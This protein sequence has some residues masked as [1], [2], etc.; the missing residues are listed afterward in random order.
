MA[1]VESTVNVTQPDHPCAEGIGDLVTND[2]LYIKL[3]WKPGNDVFLTAD[4]DGEARPHGDPWSA[5]CRP[6]P[7]PRGTA[8]P[9]G[10]YAT[11]P[12]QAGVGPLVLDTFYSI[13]EL[14]GETADTMLATMERFASTVMPHFGSK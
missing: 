11:R 4:L 12:T 8:R 13:P 7:G 2:E 3:A 9:G 1:S 10:P 6:A 14:Y 5:G